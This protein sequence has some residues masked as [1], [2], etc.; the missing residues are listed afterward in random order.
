MREPKSRFLTALF[1]KEVIDR[2]MGGWGRA[3]VGSQT[4]IALRKLPSGHGLA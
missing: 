3:D 1:Y 2:S 4:L